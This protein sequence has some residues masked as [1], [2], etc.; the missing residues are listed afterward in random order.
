M[1][2]CDSLACR[3]SLLGRANGFDGLRLMLA[4]GVMA[5][6]S[7][8]ITQGGTDAVPPVL[9]AIA[10]L[11]LPAFFALSGYLVAASL[12]RCASIREFL[13]LRLLRVLPALAIVVAATALALGP[14][15]SRLAPADYFRDPL[16]AAYFRNVLAS[17]HYLLPG[18]FEGH[19]RAGIVNGSLWTIPLELI[20]YGLLASLA[21]VARGRALTIALAALAL[22]LLFPRMPFA[23]LVFA[24]LP[25]KEL[26]LAF[27]AGALLYRLGRRVP[28]HPAI[29]LLSIGLA[30]ALSWDRSVWAAL[31]LA[32]GV[33]WLGLRRIPAWLTRADY[34]YGVYLVS[35]PL[36][37][38]WIGIF[39]NHAAWWMDLLF[40]LPAVMLC[41]AALWHGVEKPVLSRKHEIVTRLGGAGLARA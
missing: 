19:P 29:G 16:L 34:S 41:A 20:C 2:L 30:I 4:L 3:A 11:I 28:H 36:Q 24:W 25:A 15:L 27:C 39:P 40:T 9:Q 6:H 18:L 17:P 31:P 32:Y 12:S 33:I 13:A 10:R 1:A 22:L 37:Q 38:A 23:G 5:F 21:L 7:A 8:T 35:Y 26:P 14:W